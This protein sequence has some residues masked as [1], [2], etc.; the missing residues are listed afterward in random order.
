MKKLFV[1]II[2]LSLT[3]LAAC[4][5]PND[6]NASNS[7]ND[8]GA[9][10]SLKPLEVEFLT[11]ADAFQPG[12]E[13]TIKT[14]VTKGDE[15]VADAEDVQFEIWKGDNQDESAKFKPENKGEGVY[16]LKHTFNEKGIYKVIAHTTARGSHTMPIQ[17]FKVGNVEKTDPKNDHHDVD[18]MAMLMK[19][20]T[21]QANEEVTLIAHLQKGNK[22]FTSASVKLEYWK[23]GQE[24]HNF[25]ETEES[26][27]GKYQANVTFDD[28]GNYTV[29]VHFKKEEIHS[30][31]EE[32]V[33]VQQ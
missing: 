18:V 3:F 31:K 33:D 24:K 20:D 32:T 10:Q 15:N 17:E 21:I 23:S 28:P 30:H 11:E 1:L 22:P 14:Q 4:G 6:E 26:E 2:V 19:P 12:K 13:G 8:Q 29:K 7:K 16:A 25:I 27:K 5:S 9:E